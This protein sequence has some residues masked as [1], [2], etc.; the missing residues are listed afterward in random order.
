MSSK[1][2]ID[3]KRST[4]QVCFRISEAEYRDFIALL[5]NIPGAEAGSMYRA[6]F[7]RGLKAIQ[8]FYDGSNG[9]SSNAEGGQR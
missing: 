6:I 4:R 1:I 7:S 8:E 3:N 2:N 5:D 9:E